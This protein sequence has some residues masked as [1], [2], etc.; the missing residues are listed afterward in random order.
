MER[1]I[2]IFG[3]LLVSIRGIR[4]YLRTGLKGDLIRSVGIFIFMFSYYVDDIILGIIGFVIFSVGWM[5][6]VTFEGELSKELYGQVTIYKR[7][8]GD[9]PQIL[10]D[11]A[12]R[13]AYKI[14]GVTSGVLCLLIAFEFYRQKTNDIIELVEI[15]VLI[16]AG[17]L[18]IAY[19]LM[20]K[21]D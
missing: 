13:N 7:L 3:S 4:V 12:S 17:I 1:F 8:I 2:I 15:G 21:V 5:I 10:D 16:F 18:F 20:K 14:M 6:L 19:Y 9:F 11:K